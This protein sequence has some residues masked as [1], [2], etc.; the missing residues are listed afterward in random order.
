MPTLDLVDY[1]F[2]ERFPVPHEDECHR[3]GRM[4]ILD[5]KEDDDLSDGEWLA[6]QHREWAEELR[7]LHYEARHLEWALKRGIDP[8]S[9]RPPRNPGQ[10]DSIRR[11]ITGEIERTRTT[12]DGLLGDYASYFGNAAA[13][14][15]GG[16]VMTTLVLDIEQPAQVELF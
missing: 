3:A 4:G 13:D 7:Q 5:Q 11:R 2:I 1:D 12:L 6:F 14:R 16:F 15:F 10:W 9:G 8:V